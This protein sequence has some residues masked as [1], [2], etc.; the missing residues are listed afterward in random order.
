LNEF[1]FFIYQKQSEQH[2]STIVQASIDDLFTD[3][4]E[5]AI[6]SQDRVREDFTT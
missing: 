5:G 1:R 4:Q 6:P 2:I 3:I